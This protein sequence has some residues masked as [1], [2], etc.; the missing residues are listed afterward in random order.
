MDPARHT[1]TPRS[2]RG[3]NPRAGALSGGCSEV[4][5]YRNSTAVNAADAACSFVTIDGSSST[6][7]RE[8]G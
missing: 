7:T 3:T 1:R 2:P 6:G 5:G 4:G 8:V